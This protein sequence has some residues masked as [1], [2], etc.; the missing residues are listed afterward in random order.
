MAKALD[1]YD[2]AMEATYEREGNVYPQ[3]N[4]GAAIK[5]IEVMGR[6]LGVLGDGRNMSMEQLRGELDRLGF[7]LEPKNKPRAV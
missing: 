2:S 5:A 1:V 3:P 4:H 6:L 7:R